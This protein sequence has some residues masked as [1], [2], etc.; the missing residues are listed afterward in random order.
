MIRPR[1]ALGDTERHARRQSNRE[2]TCS[3]TT[4]RR[5]AAG[6]SNVA[7]FVF[8]IDAA[9]VSQLLVYPHGF[10]LEAGLELHNSLT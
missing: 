6:D 8:G 4:P 9:L 3:H 1:L 10:R 5:I 2:Q 7:T